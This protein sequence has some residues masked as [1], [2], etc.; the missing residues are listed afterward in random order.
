[1]NDASSLNHTRWECK[2][3]FM[4]E[5][6]DFSHYRPPKESTPAPGAGAGIQVLENAVDFYAFRP[7]SSPRVTT[8]SEDTA[9][10]SYNMFVLM[11]C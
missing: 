9:C 8:Y 4:I 1:M 11:T 5:P 6:Q 3:Y 2:R 10:H 7:G